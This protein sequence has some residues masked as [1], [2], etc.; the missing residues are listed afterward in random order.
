MTTIGPG[1]SW[2][3]R[4]WGGGGGRVLPRGGGRWRRHQGRSAHLDRAQHLDARRRA[5][6][7][8]QEHPGVAY[9]AVARQVADRA[10][11]AAGR[12]GGGLER[13]VAILPQSEDERRRAP[14][15]HQLLDQ[16]Q[17]AGLF[18]LAAVAGIERHEDDARG[19]LGH[20]ARQ[21]ALARLGDVEVQGLPLHDPAADQPLDL[22]AQQR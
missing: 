15:L 13:R 3:R 2:R 4:R 12:L 17:L 18:Q 21:F 20:H 8:P 9:P 22:G 19:D 16:P 7:R 11:G 6:L 1:P 5:D 10:D 14:A